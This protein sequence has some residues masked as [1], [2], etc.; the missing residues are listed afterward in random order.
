MIPPKYRKKLLWSFLLA[1]VVLSATPVASPVI[2]RGPGGGDCGGGGPTT[3]PLTEYE[4]QALNFP[5]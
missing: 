5:Q 2:A 3:G 1:I 4:K